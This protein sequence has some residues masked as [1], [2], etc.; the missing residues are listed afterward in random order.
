MV[1][2]KEGGI[3]AGEGLLETPMA[4]FLVQVR[5]GLWSGWAGGRA[6]TKEIR[7]VTPGG[8]SLQAYLCAKW[9][10]GSFPMSGG[11]SG[12]TGSTHIL[13]IATH[14]LTQSHPPPPSLRS[15]PSL[16]SH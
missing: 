2:S 15:F 3:F 7:R 12:G 6:D 10:A 8:G 14:R 11:C 9:T 1:E 4:I 16:L 5:S 13:S